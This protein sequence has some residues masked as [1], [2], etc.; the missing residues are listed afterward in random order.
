[1][2]VTIN[3]Q[4]RS[5]EERVTNPNQRFL[6][7][8]STGAIVVP[9]GNNS[10]RNNLSAQTGMFRFNSDLEKLEVRTPDGWETVSS[11]LG[12]TGQGGSDDALA[13]SIVFG[14]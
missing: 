2:S 6:R 10:Q 9:V 8:S 1:M 11:E 12:G 14:G 13:F 4:N 5:L 7:F 3:N